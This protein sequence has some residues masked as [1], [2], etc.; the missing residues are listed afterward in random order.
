M[1]IALHHLRYFV[2]VAQ[3][4][5]VSRA[6]A[7]LHISQPSLSAQIQ[8]LE[9]QVGT[10]LVH[11]NNRGITLT[12][13]GEAF[14]RHATAALEAAAAAVE[15]ARLA[16][17]G[18]TGTVKVGLIVGTQIEITSRVL[19][20]FQECHPAVTVELTEYSF[21]D[22]S[23]GLNGG[24]VD[25]AFVVLPIMHDGL[26]FLPLQESPR[27]AM[28]PQHHPLAT[29][30]RINIAELFG[31]PWAV[32]D[33]EDTVCRDFWLAA[34]HRTAPARLGQRIRSL[35]KF[36]QL[37]TSG[38]T[39]GL[40][41]DWARPSLSRPGVAF[42]EV[43]GIAPVVTALAWH[44]DRVHGLCRHFIDTAREAITPSC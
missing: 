18:Q 15:A 34:A 17:R 14:L 2:A 25:V 23:A 7:R 35:D 42:V 28:V 19:V 20:L 9:K 5:N 38:N 29:R 22:P 10:T 39:V 27:V 26:S 44:P 31:D 41:A 37:V 40:I 6:A 1:A 13:S 30:D 11:R 36:L 21:A 33:T 3:E 24:H 12:P 4:R 8:Y 32:T 16:E 43:D